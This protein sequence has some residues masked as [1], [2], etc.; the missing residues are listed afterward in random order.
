MF[1]MVAFHVR[2]SYK[3]KHDTFLKRWRLTLVND[4]ESWRTREFYR[5]LLSDMFHLKLCE[6]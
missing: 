5:A 1:C 6:K 4:S 2:H 3:K